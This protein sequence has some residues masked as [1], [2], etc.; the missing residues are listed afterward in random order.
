MPS[1][2]YGRGCRTR[3]CHGC[4][5]DRNVGHVA[6]RHLLTIDGE[7]SSSARAATACCN[8]QAPQACAVE[9]QQRLQ[10][11]GHLQITAVLMIGYGN[12]GLGWASAAWRLLKIIQRAGKSVPLATHRQAGAAMLVI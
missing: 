7:S 2:Q 12:T 6:Q 1:K 5:K 9:A 10:G 3:T 11:H 8:T 4:D